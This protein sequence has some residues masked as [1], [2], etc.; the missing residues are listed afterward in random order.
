[1]SLSAPMPVPNTM[2]QAEPGGVNCTT[3][4]PSLGRTSCMPPKPMR[5]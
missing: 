5:V 2:A 3:R 4:I 1:M